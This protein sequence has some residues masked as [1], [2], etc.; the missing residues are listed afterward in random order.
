MQVT[1][2]ADADAVV[3]RVNELAQDGKV[4]LRVQP[5]IRSR[6]GNYHA[7]TGVSWLIDCGTVDEALVLR[8]AL[9]GFFRAVNHAG[10]ERVRAVL[11]A[12]A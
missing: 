11:S 8:D 3:A 5:T 2:S 9:Q 12:V 1:Y 10:V 4:R 6:S 7:W